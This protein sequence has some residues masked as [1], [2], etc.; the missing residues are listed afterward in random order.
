MRTNKN[1]L[2]IS[3]A[4]NQHDKQIREWRVSE[5]RVNRIEMTE[6]EV[7]RIGRLEILSDLE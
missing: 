5:E 6:E 7:E 4:I 1:L 3:Q 2:Y